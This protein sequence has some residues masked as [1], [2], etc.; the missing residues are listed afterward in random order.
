VAKLLTKDE[1]RPALEV[2]PHDE[3]DSSR[4]ERQEQRD[5]KVE[6]YSLPSLLSSVHLN[7][8]SGATARARCSRSSL[9][10][11]S[12]SAELILKCWP[13]AAATLS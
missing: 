11:M 9:R 6:F 4:A 8:A 7:E 3:D 1:A 10:I 5:A 12:L 13:P 2:R